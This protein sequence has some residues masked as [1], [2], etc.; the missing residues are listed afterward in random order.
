MK[1]FFIVIACIVYTGNLLAQDS[2]LLAKQQGEFKAALANADKKLED[3]QKN[4]YD[5]QAKKVK[6]DTI[7]LAQWRYEM[8][9]LKDERRQQEIVFI[10]AHPNYLV[11]V[12][13][14]KDAVGY[15]PD[16]IRIYDKLFKG[17]NKDVQKS[18][19]G[20]SLKKKID[21]F[22]L[23][24]IG[25]EAPLFT[26]P[27]TAGHPINLKDF[28]GKYVLLDFWASWCG[29]CREENPN[30]VKAYKQFKDKN[31]TVLGVS[32]DQENKKAAWIK[33]INDDG[34]VWNQVSDLKYWSNAVAKLYSVYSVPQNFLIDPNGKIV[35]ANLRG[36]E[37][38][39]K[40]QE[41][42]FH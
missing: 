32:L 25:A 19:E 11:S 2:T 18:K 40:L 23:V 27:D 13:A 22:M 21:A 33:A 10:K 31:F 17:L 1:F 28:R 34:L 24:R 7:G 29:P 3:C 20:V 12:E 15:L 14:L 4:Y 39:K 8:K 16:D 26:Q 6:Y 36:E 30:V 5:A 41:L 37:L 38:F 9:L 35:G 42:I